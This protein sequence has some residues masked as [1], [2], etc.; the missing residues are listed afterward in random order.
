M[1]DANIKLLERWDTYEAS[2]PRREG[3]RR[4]SELYLEPYLCRAKDLDEAVDRLEEVKRSR[5]QV[6][7]LSAPSNRGK[8]A[9]ILP[10][11]CRSVDLGHEDQFTHYLYMPFANNDGNCDLAYI[12]VL[13]SLFFVSWSFA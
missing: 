7:Y 8:S 3:G 9:A 6:A 13:F 5:D 11:F 4:V 2:L 1:K 12:C 10:M